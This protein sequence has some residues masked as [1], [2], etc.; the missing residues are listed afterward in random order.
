MILIQVLQTRV[1]KWENQGE[2]QEKGME[3]T[4]SPNTALQIDAPHHISQQVKSN[5]F[6]GI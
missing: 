1:E 2:G 5:E 6:F 3:S 4:S